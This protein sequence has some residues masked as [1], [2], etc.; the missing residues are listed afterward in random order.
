MDNY[1]KGEEKDIESSIP[2]DEDVIL[3][4]PV[5]KVKTNTKVH[6]LC[7]YAEKLLAVRPNYLLILLTEI[8][9]Y[10]CFL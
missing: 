5:L 1:V 3:N 10:L 6:N 8:Y 9:L 4:V 7:G 2:F